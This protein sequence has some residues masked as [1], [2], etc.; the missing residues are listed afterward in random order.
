[1]KKNSLSMRKIALFANHKP[2]LAIAKFFSSRTN[3]DK[4]CAL[5]LPGKYEDNDA[6]IECASGVD[7]ELVFRGNDIM[8]NPDHLR[9]FTECKIDAMVCVYWPWLISKEY[10]QRV[11]VTVNF[12]P[13]LLPINRGWFPHVHSL[14]DGT[15]TGVTLHQIANEADTG[16]IWVQKPIPVQDTDTAKTLYDR[17]QLEIVKLFESNWERIASGKI[18]PTSQEEIAQP[19]YHS[20]SEVNDLD[21]IDPKALMRADNLIN[22]LRARSFGDKGFAYTEINGKRVYMNIRLSYEQDF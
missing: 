13:A 2:G 5:Y 4:I 3:S 8:R 15:P 10:F 6:Q 12:H 9:W 1:M 11:N 20:K 17:L 7:R 14:I 16:D 21:R 19:T 22:L 18:I